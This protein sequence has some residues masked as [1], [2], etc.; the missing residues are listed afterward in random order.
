MITATEITIGTE[1]LPYNEFADLC[2]D[3]K[4][5]GW[6]LFAERAVDNGAAE[7]LEYSPEL[8]PEKVSVNRT[9]LAKLAA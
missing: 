4:G 7:I 8:I 2:R 9:A 1:I 5:L 3:L 6:R